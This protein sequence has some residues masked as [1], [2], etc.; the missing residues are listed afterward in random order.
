MTQFS[1][2]LDKIAQQLK[3][4]VVYTPKELN[5]IPIY[6]ADVNRPGLLLTGYDEY[7][8]PTRIQIYGNAEMGYLSTLQ[9]AERRSRMHTLFATRPPALVVTRNLAVFSEIMEF[10]SQ[11]GVPVLRTAESTSGFMSALISMLNIEL[12]QRIT[13]HGVLVEVYGEGI[14]IL[15]ES[16]V[17]KKRDGGRTCQ[18]RPPADSRRCG[19][20]AARI[21]PLYPWHCAG[22][23][24]QLYRI[25]RRGL[26]QCGARVRHRR[27]KNESGSG[28]CG[29]AGAL[30]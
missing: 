23:Y 7:F 12:A 17:G 3:L 13:R 29:R 5:D 25:A 21:K 10:A 8:D 1:V 9:E 27:R 6:T 24:P 15:G 28:P 18:A 19:G 14:L 20:A 26:H 30:G 2:S 11:Y 22:E 4:E 16:G